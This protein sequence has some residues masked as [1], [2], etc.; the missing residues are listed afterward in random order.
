MGAPNPTV[1]PTGASRLV[2][3]Q[4]QRHLRL[5]PVADLLVRR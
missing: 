1:Q 3:R 5:A 4:I 2:Q